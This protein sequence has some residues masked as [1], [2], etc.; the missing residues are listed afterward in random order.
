MIARL[1]RQ[2]TQTFA[3]FPNLYT[4]GEPPRMTSNE[5][6]RLYDKCIRRALLQVLP[7]R[8]THWPISYAA[9]LMNRNSRSRFKFHAEHVPEYLLEEFCRVLLEFMEVEGFEDAFFVHEVR[10]IKNLTVHDPDALD[11]ADVGNRLDFLQFDNID[12]KEWH[13][14]VALEI[15]R[16]GDWVLHWTTEGLKELLEVG[17][18]NARDDHLERL[19][20]SPRLHIDVAAHIYN[21]AGFR[22]N[23]GRA[24]QE[25]RVVWLNVYTTD[26][27]P[28]YNFRHS[29]HFRRHTASELLPGRMGSVLKDIKMFTRVFNSCLGLPDYREADDDEALPEPAPQEELTAQPGAARY[30]VRVR[31]DKAPV[32]LLGLDHDVIDRHILC[33]SAEQWW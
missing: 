9:A 24:G 5:L 13:I 23:P 21:C 12:P 32:T 2:N 31:L 28:T 6:S 15:Y 3:C 19:A 25:D 10:G 20:R 8:I 1:D 17:L 22:G 18:P 14:D 30:E 26:K 7:Q 4:P 16:P 27:S 11:A 33:I 29:G